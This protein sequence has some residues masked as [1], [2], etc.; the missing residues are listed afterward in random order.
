LASIIVFLNLNALALVAPQEE[1]TA[2]ILAL[3]AGEVG[4][5]V[6]ARWIAGHVQR[7]DAPGI[8]P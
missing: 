5:D 7:L 1:A 4:E 2:M 3:A 8:Q 6:L